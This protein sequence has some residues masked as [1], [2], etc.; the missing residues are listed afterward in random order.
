MPVFNQHL[1][2]TICQ[3]LH[4]FG[5]PA[6][7]HKA[8]AELVDTWVHC[9][10]REWTV[11][12]LKSLKVDL[13][14]V[15]SGLPR[16]AKVKVNRD[17]SPYGVIGTL[18]RYAMKSE[19]S[20]QA[21]VHTLM[22]YSLF[23]NDKLSR[24]QQEKFVK[25]VNAQTS[26]IPE[27]FLK[28]FTTF[29]ESLYERK[30]EVGEPSSITFFRG[31]ESK[32]API[33]GH[34]SMPQSGA[35]LASLA[36]FDQS[37]EQARLLSRFGSIYGKVCEGVRLYRHPQR[38]MQGY[39]SQGVWGGEVHFLQE[40]GL[41]LRA[42][43]SPYL[44]H[45]VAL[46]PLGDTLY[47]HMRTLPWDCTH[48][49]DKPVKAIQSHLSGKRMIH[50][51]DLSNATDYFPLEVQLIALRAMIGNHPS[52]RLFQEIS[53]ANWKSTIGTIRWSQGQPLGLYP[54]FASFG[55]THGLLLLYL[56]GNKYQGEFYVVGDDVVILDTALYQKYMEALDFLGCPYS[57]DKS[58]SSS[59]LCEFAGKVITSLKVIPSYKWRELSDDN[60]LDI[61]RNY[62]R[63]AESLLT[64]IQRQIV[65]KV[66]HCVE[67]F[68]LGWSFEGSNLEKMTQLTRSIYKQVDRDQQSLTGLLKIAEKNWYSVPKTLS[69]TFLN[70]LNRTIDTSFISATVQNFDEKFVAALQ[71]VFPNEWVSQIE[72]SHLQGGYSGVPAA[73]KKYYEEKGFP[74]SSLLDL[75][76]EQASPSR[77]TTLDRYRNL[78][79]LK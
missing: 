79:H 34:R 17:G 45:Q 69:P 57:P 12:R 68:G 35:G 55:L 52:I 67:P 28:G 65:D 46:K 16:L 20:F 62:G 29:L 53:R 59:E 76:L 15:R 5:V 19:R 11:K 75:P 10:G 33:P 9:S 70:M 61:L 54:S 74:V 44:V 8:F 42:I 26:R 25:A 40:P 14:R 21:V 2:G 6:Y 23:K 63:R 22:V 43:A 13:Y 56:L 36:Y 7:T 49:Q 37:D 64:P 72:G 48:N 3:R 39:P 73:V 58:L 60:F 30:L 24:S 27:S 41:K 4:V 78:L 50:S 77:V 38:I 31:S 66:K 71:L 32:K 18:F 1:Q 47:S 51:V